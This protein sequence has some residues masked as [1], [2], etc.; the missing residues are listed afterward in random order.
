MDLV[1]LP[2]D[3]THE[4]YSLSNIRA[5]WYGAPKIGKSTF[6]SK[7]DNALFLATEKGLKGLDV[8]KVDIVCWEDFVSAINLLDVKEHNFR[9]IN[10]DT[11]DNLM[12][13]CLDYVCTKHRIDHPSDLKWSKGWNLLRNEF[14]KYILKLSMSNYGINFVSHEKEYEVSTRHSKYTKIGPSI[15]NQARRVVLPFVDIIGR[16]YMEERVNKLTD[17]IVERRFICFKPSMYVEAGDRTGLL[18]DIIPLRYE[19]FKKYFK[20]KNHD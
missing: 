3:K 2:K 17:Q 10:I 8:Y 6:C 19:E 9:T 15:P 4:G 18:E 20:E 14:E 1:R 16:C 12:K 7:F 11:V 13:F 5:L